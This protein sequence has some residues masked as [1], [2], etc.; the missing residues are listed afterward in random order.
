MGNYT[1]SNSMAAKKLVVIAHSNWRSRIN[2]I[3]FIVSTNGQNQIMIP[4]PPGN[5]QF[6][7]LEKP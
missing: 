2:F 6:Y 7:R 5:S 3:F 1:Q 4:L